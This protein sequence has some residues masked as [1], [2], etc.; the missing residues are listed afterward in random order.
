[1]KKRYFPFLILF[2]L[3]PVT[4]HG[5]SDLFEI[6][7]PNVMIIFDTSS[8]MNMD[9]NGVS[10][11]SGNAKGVDGVT[12]E[13]QGGGNHPNSKLFIAKQALGNALKG[14]ENINLGLGT[15]GQRKQ[16]KYRARYKKYVITQAYQPPKNWCDK[17]YYRWTTTNDT[18]PRYATSFSLNSFKDAWGTEHKDVEKNVYTFQRKIWIHDK[19]TYLHPPYVSGSFQAI[20]E[21]W[22]QYKVTDIT[23]NAEYNWYV[24]KYEVQTPAYD[25]Y[26]E[27]TRKIDPCGSCGTDTEDNPFS[28]EWAGPP[29]WK[30]YF[31]GESEY[32]DP[33]NGRP[34]KWWDC[35]T[36]SSPEVKE[37]WDWVYQWRTYTGPLTNCDKTQSDGWDYVNN[38]HDVSEYYYPI[39][40]SPALS[41]D[42]VNRPHTWSYFKI[43]SDTW[44]ESD[45]P[46]PFYPAPTEDLESIPTTSSL[47]TS[48]RLMMQQMITR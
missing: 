44:K 45:Q 21:Y 42:S 12:R 20:K 13:Y 7:M 11:P 48:R 39:G 6:R 22:I 24:F 23:Y 43:T 27:T 30:T 2:L 47:S 37:K 14:I 25:L 46:N 38:C 1:M 29:K 8:S 28:R 41:Y 32:N 5:Q 26:Q 35:T 33:P 16:E 3:L 10:V 40:S 4:T 17:R 19:A 31:S 18:S 9:V 34:K 15:Y 36:G